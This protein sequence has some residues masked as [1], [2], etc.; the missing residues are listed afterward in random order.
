MLGL[1]PSLHSSYNVLAMFWGRRGSNTLQVTQM[2]VVFF[3]AGNI[4]INPTVDTILFMF[5][6][7]SR[8]R[9]E[10]AIW[11]VNL[12]L[13]PGPDKDVLPSTTELA[14]IAKH[15]LGECEIEAHKN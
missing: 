6:G 15:G 5:T 13:L 14:E 12:F 8:G 2:S 7:E 10:N 3:H 9:R 1:D 11:Q 4:L